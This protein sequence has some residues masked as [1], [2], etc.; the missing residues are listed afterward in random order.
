MVKESY[1]QSWYY[2]FDPIC[3]SWLVFCFSMPK[4]HSQATTA[5]VRTRLFVFAGLTSRG[6]APAGKAKK[7][8]LCVT[9][10]LHKPRAINACYEYC[11]VA[12]QEEKSGFDLRNHWVELSYDCLGP[13]PHAYS[14]ILSIYMFPHF[15]RG[16]NNDELCASIH[17]NLKE[18][19]KKPP[20]PKPYLICTILCII[21][22]N[23][24]P[25]AFPAK[26][27][28][29][30]GPPDI[31]PPTSTSITQQSTCS[32]WASTLPNISNVNS[33]EN[34]PNGFHESIRQGKAGRSM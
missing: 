10:A 18:E 26:L 11:D 3:P 8:Q 12:N 20:N 13:W 14:K 25:V 33:Q 22:K 24:Y 2:G 28:Q 34:S 9:C 29:R 30:T 1:L 27:Q 16:A 21:E 17:S 19:P 15:K 32:S 23:W 5:A 4:V 31:G 6:V 7:M